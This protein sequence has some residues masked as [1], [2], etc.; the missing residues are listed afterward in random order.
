VLS[1]LRSGAINS[2]HLTMIVG[3][4]PG[5]PR[6]MEILAS[7]LC[8]VCGYLADGC[9]YQS[10]SPPGDATPCGGYRLIQAMLDCGAVTT[11]EVK[12]LLDQFNNPEGDSP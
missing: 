8:A 11:D 4:V 6:K 10:L 12:I 7:R 1:G 3:S 5:P 2:S 9:D